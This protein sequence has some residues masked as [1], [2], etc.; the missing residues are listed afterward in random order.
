MGTLWIQCRILD[1]EMQQKY[2]LSRPYK[3]LAWF[4]FCTGVLQAFGHIKNQQ[5][6][7]FSKS[8]QIGSASG[9]TGFAIKNS[10]LFAVSREPKPYQNPYSEQAAKRPALRVRCDGYGNFAISLYPAIFP[11]EENS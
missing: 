5:K 9:F 3:K 4:F 2:I 11:T 7:I 10:Q 8:P 1:S 6:A